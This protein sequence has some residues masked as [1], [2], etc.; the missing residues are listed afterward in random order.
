MCQGIAVSGANG[1]GKT[2]L[3]RLLAGMLGYKHMDAEDYFFKEPAVPYTDARTR[4]EALKLLTADMKKYGQ[5][6]VTAVNC[7]FG[8]EINARY[9]CV[10]YIEAP[11]EIRLDRIKKRSI[12]KFGKRVFEGGDMYEREQKFY[13]LAA[14]RTMEKTEA[15]LNGLKCPVIYIDGTKPAQENAEAFIRQ[16]IKSS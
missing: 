15:W 16:W 11:L 13:E 4:E 6:I 9:G 3:G 12:E 5:F 8:D 14:S 2:T 1:S 10:I 7:D